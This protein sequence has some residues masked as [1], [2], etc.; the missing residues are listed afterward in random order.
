M[1]NWLVFDAEIKRCIASEGELPV[2]G[3]AYCAG[4]HDFAGMGVAT[5]CCYDIQ[6]SRIRV[7]DEYSL[8]EFDQLARQREGLVGWNNKQF[9]NPLLAAAGCDLFDLPT[10]DLADIVWRAAGV[11]QGE[12]PKGLSLDAVCRANGITGKTGNGADAPRWWQDGHHA[13]VIDYCIGD[14]YSTLRLLRRMIDAHAL[15][16]PRNP[17]NFL[18]VVVPQ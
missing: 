6:D 7:F 11:P 5:L 1:K 3:Y 15:R 18:H 8:D 17:E 2:D 10:I 9:D 13:R 12:H 4:W 16:D 14:V